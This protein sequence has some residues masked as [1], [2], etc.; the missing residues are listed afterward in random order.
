MN[1]KRCKATDSSH[2][3][4]ANKGVVPMPHF[5]P[6]TSYTNFDLI[7]GRVDTAMAHHGIPSED[8]W[9]L[10]RTGRAPPFDHIDAH[11]MLFPSDPD[12]CLS[13]F[14][15]DPSGNAFEVKWYLDFG[16]MFH[17]SGEVGVG[18]LMI[19]NSL[20]P[21][22]FPPAVR[23]LMQQRVRKG[24]AVGRDAEKRSG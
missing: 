9:C 8:L 7:R 20:V 14:L 16:E 18:G 23:A 24:D 22:H 11:N 12:S 5:G 10:A 2:D 4:G 3:M 1:R 15:T 21:E 13:Q 19:D 17:H 6:N